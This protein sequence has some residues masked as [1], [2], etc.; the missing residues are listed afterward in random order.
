MQIHLKPGQKVKD[1]GHNEAGHRVLEVVDKKTGEVVQRIEAEDSATIDVRNED[2]DSVVGTI[3]EVVGPA[4]R[5]ND[6]RQN[7]RV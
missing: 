7:R 3:N 2:G 6:P 4:S 1:L 5:M